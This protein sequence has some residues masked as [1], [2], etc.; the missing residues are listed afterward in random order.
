M[1]EVF[2]AQSDA[3]I[4]FN[5]NAKLDDEDQGGQQVHSLETLQ[6]PKFLFTNTESI[7]LFGIDLQELKLENRNFETNFME[8]KKF[9]CL[10]GYDAD[11]NDADSQ[12][13]RGKTHDKLLDDLQLNSTETSDQRSISLAL[14]LKRNKIKGVEMYKM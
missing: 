5:Q 1:T 9:I 14:L 8:E 10:D 13:D 12:R 2:N 3:V 6:L 4:V 7:N 11:L